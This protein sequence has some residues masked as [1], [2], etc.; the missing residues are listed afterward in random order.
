MRHIFASS[1]RVVVGSNRHT[2]CPGQAMQFL[3]AQHNIRIGFLRNAEQIQKNSG[4]I[5]KS[6]DLIEEI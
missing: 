1:P 4:K 3:V 2:G 5:L 6:F